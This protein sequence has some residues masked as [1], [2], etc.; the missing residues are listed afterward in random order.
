M[1]NNKQRLDNIEVFVPKKKR[2]EKKDSEVAITISHGPVTMEI[3]KK[4]SEFVKG[5][6]LKYRAE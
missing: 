2:V 5:L 4:I 3:V 6:P 1:M